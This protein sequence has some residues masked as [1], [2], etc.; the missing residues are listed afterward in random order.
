MIT[1]DELLEYSKKRN[2]RNIGHAEKDY[3]QNVLLYII[4]Q[5]NGNSLVFKGGTA[6]SK[7]YGLNR[8]SED[9]D[10]T[11]SDKFNIDKLSE[12]LNRFMIEHEIEKEEKFGNLTVIIRIK[13]PLYNGNRNS[14]CKILLDISYREKVVIKSNRVSIGRFMEEI[15]IFDVMVMD[16]KEI[17]AEKVR[18]SMTRDKARD[19]YDLLF[20]LESGEK[21]DKII[22]NEKLNYYKKKFGFDSFIKSLK[23]KKDIWESEMSGLMIE[24]P[25]F[26]EV[27]A[28]I[29][30][31]VKSQEFNLK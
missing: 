21:L 23:S 30:K 4:Y 17:L 5:S 27:V 31:L 29:T 13:G 16:K 26:D 24:I 2:L 20:L 11:A 9:L 15:P 10:F 12:G 19:V 3:I 7:C 1:R 8:F 28:K 18:A 14:L 25:K 6:L 22:I